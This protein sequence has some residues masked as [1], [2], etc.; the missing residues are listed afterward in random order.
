MELLI[1]G[2]TV[3]LGRHLVDAALAAGHEVTLANRGRT[4]A[5]LFPDVHRITVDRASD[6]LSALGDGKWDAV[7]DTCGY[8]PAHVRATAEALAD[9]A[10][11][12]TFVSSI[13]VYADVSKPGVDEDAPVG[14]LD[15][16]SVSEVTGET[17]GPLKAL[18]EQAAADVFADRCLN[19]RPGLIVGPWD[20]SDRFTYWPRRFDQ[21]GEAIVP[22][23]PDMPVQLADVR[24]LAEW[25]VRAA[26]ARVSG[27]F[28]GCGPATPWTLRAVVDA[29]RAAAGD[30][31]AEP[32]WVD[33]AFLLEHEVSPWGELPLWIPSTSDNAAMLAVSVDRAVAAG[34]TYRPLST[35]VADTLE[36]DRS[37][38][39]TALRGP[40]SAEKEAAVLAAWRETSD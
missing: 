23:W 31:A 12:Y 22:G 20:P 21:G 36:W 30:G 18:C 35:V 13:S 15:D 26:E 1:L 14:V 24:D 11:H 5:G 34:M 40:L 28:N 10:G 37:R 17:Y 2:G 4:N 32:V 19:V 9:R 16:P 3:F 39:D 38:R 7:I 6:D 33:E 25:M 27:T 29:C 8:L